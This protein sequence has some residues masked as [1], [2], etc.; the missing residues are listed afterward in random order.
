MKNVACQMATI[1]VM[2]M[3]RLVVAGTGS[4]AIYAIDDY[5]EY[6]AV[7]GGYGQYG[8]GSGGGGVSQYGCCHLLITALWQ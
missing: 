4:S 1:A 5:N 3:A 2:T 8:N 6:N 7:H